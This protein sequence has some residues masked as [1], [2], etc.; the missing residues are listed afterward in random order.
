MDHL[1][2][3]HDVTR[4]LHDLKIIVVG[5]GKRGWSSGR[6]NDTALAQRPVLRAVEFMS[7]IP[8]YT[9]GL[10]LLPLRCQRRYLSV[11]RVHD[12]G[13]SRRLYN[14]CS[15]VSPKVIVASAHIG[16]GSSVSSFAV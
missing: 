8:C 3:N 5:C 16:F 13:G 11:R 10:S 2:E 14:V 7:F 6:P 12:Q 9:L 4:S 15:A 1:N